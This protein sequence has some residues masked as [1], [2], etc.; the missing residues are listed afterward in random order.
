[1][2]GLACTEDGAGQQLETHLD[3]SPYASVVRSLVLLPFW[4]HNNITDRASSCLADLLSPRNTCS[5]SPTITRLA[6]RRT[7]SP[8]SSALARR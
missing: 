6:G 5:G 8:P 2:R 3:H 1:M 4:A 7:L